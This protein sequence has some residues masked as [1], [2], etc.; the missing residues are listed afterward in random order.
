MLIKFL[1][2][3]VTRF[4]VCYCLFDLGMVHGL[5]TK[6]RMEYNDENHPKGKLMYQHFKKPMNT[7]M[8]VEKKSAIRDKETRAI[9]TQSVIRI[10]TNSHKDLPED[11]VK[12]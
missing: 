1:V 3:D 5:D 10:L 2:T 6:V 12:N 8:V 11:E 9:H 4:S 7:R